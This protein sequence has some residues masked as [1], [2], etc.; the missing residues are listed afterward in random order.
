M[1]IS[2]RYDQLGPCLYE[3]CPS[4]QFYNYKAMAIG[5]RA[6]SAKTYLEK[7]FEKFENCMPSAFM[8]LQT[9][10]NAACGTGSGGAWLKGKIC[11]CL[12]IQGGP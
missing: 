12:L 2:N 4:G 8:Y 1:L 11:S 10:C 9:H 5:A 6:Q 3:T 7:N